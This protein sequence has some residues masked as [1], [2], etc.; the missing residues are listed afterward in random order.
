MSYANIDL[1]L[2]DA[3]VDWITCTAP[4]DDGALDLASYAEAIV[5]QQS[6]DGDKLESWGVHGYRGFQAG[7]VRWGWGVLGTMAVFSGELAHMAAPT[8]ATLARHWSRVDYQATVLDDDLEID[9]PSDYWHEADQA[10]LDAKT[11]VPLDRHQSKT[12]GDSCTIGS[13]ASAKYARCYDKYSESKGDYPLGS[14]RWELE[15]KREV[16][17]AQHLRWRQSTVPLAEQLGYIESFFAGYSLTVPFRTD[18]DV[19]WPPR[20]HRPRDADRLLKWFEVQVAPSVRWVAQARGRDAVRK[21][22]NI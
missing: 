6:R 17:E 11:S 16:S 15:L 10:L 21:A 22:L 19:E 9:P 1:R 20:F 3:G 12:G 7:G 8:L 2:I 4:R 18:A 13:R 5:Q 14:W